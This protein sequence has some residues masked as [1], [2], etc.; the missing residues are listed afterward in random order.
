[1]YGD[2]VLMLPSGSSTIAKPPWPWNVTP[3]IRLPSLHKNT[4]ISLLFLAGLVT[5]NGLVK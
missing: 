3:I 5:S 4:S 1:M 2:L